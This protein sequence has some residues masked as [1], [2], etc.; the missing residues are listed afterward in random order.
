MHI[1]V[2]LLKLLSERL[3]QS[4][5][6]QNFLTGIIIYNVT[7]AVYKTQHGVIVI[8]FEK[9][10]IFS[11]VIFKYDSCGKLAFASF[12]P[13]LPIPRSLSFDCVRSTYFQAVIGKY[14][15]GK[16]N[17]NKFISEDNNRPRKSWLS[18]L[19]HC[20]F[21]WMTLLLPLA[22]SIQHRG[23]FHPSSSFNFC[24]TTDH[25]STLMGKFCYQ[26]SCLFC[27]HSCHAQERHCIRYIEIHRS[28][29]AQ[30]Q[31]L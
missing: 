10:A 14:G 24:D 8:A 5:F 17:R 28:L 29:L 22:T 21:A 3:W 31:G 19:N 12:V 15:E 7:R 18:Y 11:E 20:T 13:R 1:A 27:F 26:Y 25:L 4:G 23:E 2:R 16:I 6:A 30:F 9:C